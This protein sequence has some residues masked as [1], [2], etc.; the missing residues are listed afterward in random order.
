MGLW[1]T[2]RWRVRACL[3]VMAGATVFYIAVLT[4]RLPDLWSDPLGRMG[5]M[6][7]LFAL[8]AVLAAIEDER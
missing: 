2:L 4:W 7:P 6:L 1:L 5:E 8:M 3:S